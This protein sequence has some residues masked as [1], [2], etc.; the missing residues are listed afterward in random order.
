[1]DYAGIQKAIYAAEA[2]SGGAT[3]VLPAG[4]CILS[5][6]VE[7]ERPT[8]IV[9]EGAM[10]S[11]GVP[12][13]T[14]TDTVN[15]ANAGGDVKVTSN[16]NRVQDMILDQ[17]KYGQALYVRANNTTVQDMTILG[18]TGGFAAY[19]TGDGVTARSKGN[20]LLDSTVVSLINHLVPVPSG[21]PCGDGLVWAQ[22]D[23]SLVQNVHFTGTRIALF[24]DINT[25]VDGYT[26]HPGPQSCDLDGFYITQPSSG[27]SLSDLTMYGSAG[28]IGFGGATGSLSRSITISRERVLDP[29]PGKGFTLNGPSHGLLIRDTDGVD[30]TASN[31]DSGQQANSGIELQPS[32]FARDVVVSGSVVPRVSFWGAV[33]TGSS[34]AATSHGEFD[35]D[36]FPAYTW[37]GGH[38]DTFINGDGAPASFKVEGGTFSNYQPTDLPYYGLFRGTNTSFTVNGLSGYPGPT[39]GG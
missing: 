27:I 39:G 22:Q 38:T 3:V 25:T 17:T 8:P 7:M 5:K 36:T 4:D 26:Y 30:I 18:G 10:S 1:V 28:V 35:S 6:N 14:L 16:G 37:P 20:R 32:T 15:P 24:Q 33:A 29:T 19:F 2:I 34:P 31:F 11:T 23:R 13:T 9:L 12:L 21:H